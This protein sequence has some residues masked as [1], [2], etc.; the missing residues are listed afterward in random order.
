MHR[1]RSLVKKSFKHWGCR[2]T[3]YN[4]SIHPGTFFLCSFVCIRRNSRTVFEV[5]PITWNIIDLI[6]TAQIVALPLPIG[7]RVSI[8][9]MRQL[10]TLPQ[11]SSGI[12]QMRR[13][14]R[15]GSLSSVL[16]ARLQTAVVRC[17]LWGR[18][19]RGT[20]PYDTARRYHI[21]ATDSVSGAMVLTTAAWAVRGTS[22][23]S[24]PQLRHDIKLNECPCQPVVPWHWWSQYLYHLTLEAPLPRVWTIRASSIFR[25]H[26]SDSFCNYHLLADSSGYVNNPNDKLYADACLW[27]MTPT[28][29]TIGRVSEWITNRKSRR[30]QRCHTYTSRFWAVE[31]P[32]RLSTACST[33]SPGA[34][35]TITL[36]T[37]LLPYC[38]HCWSIIS[39]HCE[40]IQP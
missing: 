37:V 18:V 23:I 11:H 15:A 8:P 35:I 10:I 40:I 36:T 25:I 38:E 26:I 3:Q 33:I 14:L 24:E 1:Y 31:V 2:L 27:R 7:A 21:T 20:A 16:S 34:V 6:A 32:A 19:D 9:V 22:D 17:I 29:R 39:H 12:L 28:V 5:R 30:Q 13:I 4:H